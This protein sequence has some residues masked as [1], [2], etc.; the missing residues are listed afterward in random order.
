MRHSVTKMTQAVRRRL[1]RVVRKSREKE[2]ALRASAVLHL[3]ETQVRVAEAPYR[4]R[5]A[6]SS[7]YRW[8]SLYEMYGEDG[9][10]PQARGR[11]DWK[12]NEEVLSM[13]ES[14]VREDPR[15]LG[16]L[17]SRW[18][19]QRQAMELE[20]RSG[21]AVHAT[22]VRP[23][24]ERLRF[25]FRWASPLVL[26]VDNYGIH[27]SRVTQRW[28]EES[29]KFELLFDLTYH[30]WVNVIERL[31]KAMHE[32]VTRN[33]RCRSMFELYHSVA[34]PLEVVQPYHGN[35]HAVAHLGPAI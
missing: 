19:S 33:H 9:I 23:W 11:S 3:W 5:A 35:G 14:I 1:E 20:S 13:L 30:P 8:Q 28:L 12:A 21:V 7:V 2:Y 24:L 27:K 17:R 10:R 15:G 26:I 25:R 29:P 34:R 18:S 31:W 32:T 6:R 16:Y 4:V 22:T